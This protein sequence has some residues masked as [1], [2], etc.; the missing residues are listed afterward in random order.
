[1]TALIETCIDIVALGDEKNAMRVITVDG[2][3]MV[4]F[5]NDFEG[6]DTQEKLDALIQARLNERTTKG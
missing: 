6:I 2:Y 5:N 4:F 3:S 1:M